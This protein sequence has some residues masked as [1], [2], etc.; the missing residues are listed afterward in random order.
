MILNSR[1]IRDIIIQR[2]RR[3]LDRERHRDARTTLTDIER[4]PH[5]TSDSIASGSAFTISAVRVDETS[6]EDREE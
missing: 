3:G 6:D 4:E 5:L 2:Q 1:R